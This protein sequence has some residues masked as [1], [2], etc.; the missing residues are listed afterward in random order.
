[1]T[2]FSGYPMAQLTTS[3]LTPKEIAEAFALVQLA[4]PRASFSNWRAY[5]N[6]VLRIGGQGARGFLVARDQHR[7]ILGILHYE[8]RHYLRQGRLMQASEILTCG[9]SARHR[10]SVIL[11]LIRGLET[12]AQR[13][14]CACLVTQVPQS[15]DAEILEHLS[16]LLR[17]SGHQRK[18]HGYLKQL[19]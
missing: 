15:A 4:S 9:A 14:F 12:L 13:E 6:G 1:M 2:Q 3:R 17:A 18:N 19:N 16:T 10:L 7:I 5:T 11:A 8:V